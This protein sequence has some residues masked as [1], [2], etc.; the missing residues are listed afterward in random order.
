MK[1]IK[2]IFKIIGII[3][4]CHV[5]TGVFI[6]LIYPLLLDKNGNIFADETYQDTIKQNIGGEI[7]RNIHHYNDL[8][9][10]DYVI[11]YTYKNQKDSISTIGSGHYY[12]KNLPANEQLIKFGKWLIFKTSG[13]R[14]YD[15]VF[16]C[17]T[18]THIWN[19]YDISPYGIEDEDLWINQHIESDLGN[20]DSEAKVENIDGNGNITVRYV[21][22]KKDRIFSFIKGKRKIIYKINA[23]TGTPEMKV[24]SK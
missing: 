6:W 9:S 21:Y 3:V 4:F 15:F 16:I 18:N 24:I 22:A 5:I 17:D 11:K 1:K 23:K 19:K 10:F 20:W 7:I 13:G 14:E 12:C 8:Q 2:F